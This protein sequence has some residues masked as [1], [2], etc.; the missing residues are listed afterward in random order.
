MSK[1]CLSKV[2]AVASVNSF[3]NSLRRRWLYYV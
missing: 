2:I 1:V 3:R